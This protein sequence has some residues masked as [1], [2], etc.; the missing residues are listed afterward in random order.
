[1]IVIELMKGGDLRHW[2]IKRKREKS[3]QANI[4]LNFCRQICLGMAYLSSR[5]FVH[6]DLA[7]RNILVT[8]DNICKVSDEY[9]VYFM[10]N[11]CTIA[12]GFSQKMAKK[13]PP[14]F[15]TFSYTY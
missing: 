15:I 7:A 6:R 14:I 10:K 3:Y 8:H 5:K 2:L 1:M 9:I 11:P 12:H 4:L 13:S